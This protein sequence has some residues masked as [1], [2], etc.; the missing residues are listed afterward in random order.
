L[1]L[2]KLSAVQKTVKL[3]GVAYLS[4]DPDS[5]IMGG[6]LKLHRLRA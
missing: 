1:V 4:S 6:L 2:V 5:F 3:L